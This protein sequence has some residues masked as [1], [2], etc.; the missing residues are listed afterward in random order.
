MPARLLIVNAAS[1]AGP[2]REAVTDKI[3]WQNCQQP[4]Q[5]IGHRAPQHVQV[6]VEVMVNEPVPHPRGRRPRH[7]RVGFAQVMAN[8]TALLAASTR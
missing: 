1:I 5:V 2:R 6:D 4:G 7:F 3:F 8:D